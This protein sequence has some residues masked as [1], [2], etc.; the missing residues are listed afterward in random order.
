MHCRWPRM[1]YRPVWLPACI[2][3]LA[4]C[5]AVCVNASQPIPMYYEV[6]QS[7][8]RIESVASF[9]AN[10]LYSI[11]NRQFLFKYTRHVVPEHGCTNITSS[12]FEP[13][14]I[15]LIADGLCDLEEKLDRL[16]EHGIGAAFVGPSGSTSQFNMPPILH[17]GRPL[18]PLL[19]LTATQFASFSVIA[20]KSQVTVRFPIVEPDTC[21]PHLVPQ[22]ATVRSDGFIL[23]IGGTFPGHSAVCWFFPTSSTTDACIVESSS[24]FPEC[25]G[26][27]SRVTHFNRTTVRC[28]IPSVVQL[29]PARYRVTVESD[30]VVGKSVVT[31]CFSHQHRS[32]LG[33]SSTSFKPVPQTQSLLKVLPDSCACSQQAGEPLCDVPLH[34]SIDS[35][36]S[37]LWCRVSESC[38]AAS[39][40]K[41]TPTTGIAAGVEI[42][43]TARTCMPSNVSS[44]QP[45]QCAVDCRGISCRGGSALTLSSD[46][47]STSSLRCTCAP[48]YSG[49]DCNTPI[50][51][52]CV[53]GT[54]VGPE[55]CTCSPFWVG[56]ACDRLKCANNCTQNGLCVGVDR[57]RCFDGYSGEDCSVAS[58]TG[59]SRV[60]VVI[61]SVTCCVLFLAVVVVLYIKKS[62]PK[63][64]IRPTPSHVEVNGLV[65]R[66]V[67]VERSFLCCG[68]S[69]RSVVDS[70]D[71]EAVPS[72]EMSQLQHFQQ[73]QQVALRHELQ[74]SA[75]RPR[76]PQMQHSTHRPSPSGIMSQR[77]VSQQSLST[78]SSQDML[79]LP[80]AGLPLS[81]QHRNAA[82]ASLHRRHR[83]GRATPRNLGPLPP[84]LQTDAP[85]Y[86]R[87][88]ARSGRQL[89]R[90]PRG[91]P[92]H[93]IPHTASLSFLL[94]DS[95][96]ASDAV[97]ETSTH[98]YHQQRRQTTRALDYPISLE[99]ISSVSSASSASSSSDSEQ[100]PCNTRRH[101]RSGHGNNDHGDDEREDVDPSTRCVS[102]PHAATLH[103]ENPAFTARR[104]SRVRIGNA[105]ANSSMGSVC[106][107]RPCSAADNDSHSC[108]VGSMGSR[109]SSVASLPPPY[110]WSAEAPPA[111][112][113]TTFPSPSQQP[114]HIPT[115]PASINTTCQ[116]TSIPH[117]VAEGEGSEV[118]EEE[119][120]GV[121]PDA[122]VMDGTTN[123][124]PAS[125]PSLP[126]F[127]TT[128]SASHLSH[129]PPLSRRAFSSG[130]RSRSQG[131]EA[132]PPLHDTQPMEGEQHGCEGSGEAHSLGVAP[133]STEGAKATQH[134]A[135]ANATAT[136][137]AA[138]TAAVAGEPNGRRPLTAPA[139]HRPAWSA[140]SSPSSPK[141]TIAA[142]RTNELR[143]SHC[144]TSGTTDIPSHESSS[145]SSSL[146]LSPSL[147][148]NGLPPRRQPAS[149]SSSSLQRVAIAGRREDTTEERNGN[150][151]V[152]AVVESPSRVRTA[153][154]PSPLK[155]LLRMKR[156]RHQSEPSVQS[157]P[158]L[159]Q[160][161]QSQQHQSQHQRLQ[162]TLE[163]V[164]QR[165]SIDLPSASSRE[166]DCVMST[167]LPG[168]VSADG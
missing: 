17:E 30:Y 51:S 106:D 149:S 158:T 135:T 96:D 99:Y 71:T 160:L 85:R 120:L 54:C 122:C 39:K 65:S 53:S 23:D 148:A 76:Q 28:P 166:Q 150:T 159:H 52:A 59:I 108:E 105:A 87:T 31:K 116:S 16:H 141:P 130:S 55:Q 102:T 72:Y 42:V 136:T 2:V 121:G 75:L 49:Q 10:S 7:S 140:R 56:D 86:R 124:F 60:S 47:L 132:T 142:T 11:K 91:L 74:A 168:A 3:M 131:S 125:S 57:C 62:P 29:S 13:T 123:T 133:V 48:G 128:H 109:T 144:L 117:G 95:T 90:A 167:T 98:E 41:Y 79:S 147:A 107:H 155:Q 97:S 61:L 146:S 12:T 44:L 139:S 152:A 103:V 70:F 115:A 33:W 21:A 110:S 5:V 113:E 45:V 94:S 126:L 112:C 153:R 6:E 27:R 165:P 118:R 77:P 82:A 22:L 80:R 64:Y 84:L 63:V 145:P 38:A 9:Y 88:Y 93:A 43:V 154:R 101:A 15:A 114:Q 36:H 58:S 8:Q 83:H 138:E 143:P 92:F 14:D 1:L 73:E 24:S 32:Q 81:R 67:T 4:C 137:V 37:E 40:V 35:L 161:L 69:R 164:S 50:C 156:V 68:R 104:E 34:T 18:I 26:L 25:E 100:E 89:S 46:L 127:G 134:A 78:T 111:A 129:S 20:S 119:E 66:V 151:A 163:T 19:Q 157:P 162:P